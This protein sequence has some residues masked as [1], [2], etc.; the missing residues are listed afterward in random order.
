MPD[1]ATTRHTMTR[2][3]VPTGLS[4][5]AFCDAFESLVPLF[6]ITAIEHLTA[7]GGSWD[8]VR[9]AVAANAPNDL[10]IFATVDAGALMAAA[11]HTTR[12]IEYLIGNHVVAETMFRHNPLVMLYAPLRV[13]V[14]S[15]DHDQAV[16]SID[17]PSVLLASLDDPRITRVGRDLDLKV[18]H[19]LSL[20]GID[21]T[22]AF[23]QGHP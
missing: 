3:D 5:D 21:A 12:A 14:H 15:T 17:Q 9:T 23:T 8:D 20:I 2:I 18:A 1:T 7:A 19:V 22:D 10:M 6:D 11:G 16:F 4:Y 13:L